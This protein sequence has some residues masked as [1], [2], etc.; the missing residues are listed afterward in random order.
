MK[1]ILVIFGGNSPEHYVSCRSAKSIAENLDKRLFE[2]ELVGIDF[3]NRWYKFKDNLSYLE[4]G[5][6]KQANIL[7]V[8]NVIHYLNKFDVVFPIIYGV[9]GEDGKLEGMLELLQVRFVGSKTLT[10]SICR[11]REVLKAMFE[12]L[13]IPQIPYLVA[14]NEE[15]IQ[16]FV[17]KFGFPVMVK[18]VNKDS[19]IGT[20]K[21]ENI[22]QLKQAIQEIKKYE[23]KAIVEKYVNVKKLGC[24]VLENNRNLLCSDPGEIDSSKNQEKED[25]SLSIDIKNQMKNLAKRVF[26]GLNCNSYAEVNF[27][28]DEEE[29][30]IYMNHVQTI[31][32]FNSSYLKLMEKEG[33][34]YQ[35]LLTIL[36]GNS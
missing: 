9:N 1:K 28:Y 23:N 22:E 26:L 17:N 30:T 19:S 4:K 8:D 16:K 11:N 32:K 29:K 20:Q 21:I 7:E 14:Q 18:S 31:P 27:L 3:N 34:C 35:E 15:S 10:S 5:N 12:Q 36:I 2:Y 6:W 13:E 25:I 24:T 33:I